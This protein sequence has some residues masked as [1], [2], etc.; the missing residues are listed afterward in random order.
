M[1]MHMLPR[2]LA[3]YVA[4]VVFW[5]GLSTAWPAV[6]AYHAQ[7]LFWARKSD[8]RAHLRGRM[9]A[10]DVALSLPAA[11]AGPLVYMLLPFM[12]RT[13]LS[14]WLAGHGLSRAS[15]LIMIPYFGLVHPVLEQVHWAPLRRR[16]PLAHLCFAGYHAFVL[17]SL[18]T[19]AW[20]I[21][22]VAVL[23]LASLLWARLTDRS[24][25]LAMPVLS[26][27]LADTGIILAACLRAQ[28]V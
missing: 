21:L 27:I 10:R 4:V 12:T 18:L 24:N 23:T 7:I 6:L 13:D 9:R 20:L 2:L 8:R 15:L 25:S 3:P 19:P 22:C 16:T 1:R 17:Y 14:A 11:L 5:C 26:H 28:P